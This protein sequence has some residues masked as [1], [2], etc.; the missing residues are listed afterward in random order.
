MCAVYV[1]LV[2][3]FHNTLWSVYTSHNV[4]SV[5]IEMFA[6]S[7]MESSIYEQIKKK[8]EDISQL[9]HISAAYLNKYFLNTVQTIM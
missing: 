2:M 6:L 3:F 8:H 7:H 5:Y 1:W 4:Y 9:N